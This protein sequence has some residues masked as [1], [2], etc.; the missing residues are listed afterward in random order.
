M[1]TLLTLHGEIVQELTNIGKTKQAG[2]EQLPHC[3][4]VPQNADFPSGDMVISQRGNNSPSVGSAH[5]SP[6]I[7][8]QSWLA[9][10]ECTR[11]VF[12][13][14]SSSQADT[15]RHVTCFCS[16]RD[17]RISRSNLGLGA[18]R[19]LRAHRHIGERVHTYTHPRPYIYISVCM[20]L[21]T[22]GVC[23]KDKERERVINTFQ[24]GISSRLINP[25]YN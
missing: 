12:L 19:A 24:D 20:L 22:S 15:G 11:L 7:A 16:L 21:N 18:V 5:V 9:A 10:C 2:C 23:V 3:L 25:L 6:L 1:K 4:Q 14:A 8:C 13:G 17:L